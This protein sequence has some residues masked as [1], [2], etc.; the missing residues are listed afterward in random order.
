MK[1]KIIL[2]PTINKSIL[3]LTYKLFL[4]EKD[5]CYNGQHLYIISDD[6]IKEGDY[7]L[8]NK[9]SIFKIEKDCEY[10][11]DFYKKI[12]STTDDSLNLPI[13]KNSYIEYYVEQY[14][15]D[16]ILT[17]VE[18]EVDSFY[19]ISE[20]IIYEYIK[21]VKKEFP[22]MNLDYLNFVADKFIK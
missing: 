22:D 12:I 1:C 14:N 5:D 11:T 6:D 7:I 9:N 17:E 16:N 20:H 19:N 3:D 18:V 8:S 15:K 4:I 13:I 21:E 2:L 10:D